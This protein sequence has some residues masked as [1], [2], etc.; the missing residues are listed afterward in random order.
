MCLAAEAENCS[1]MKFCAA[2]T[3]LCSAFSSAAELHTTS[4]C[5]EDTPSSAAAEGQQQFQVDFPRT[6]K[7]IMCMSSFMRRSVC[8]YLKPVG[9]AQYCGLSL[10]L[11][12]LLQFYNR[13]WTLL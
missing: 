7:E 12:G 3:T 6:S 11:K 5:H 13:N 10:N 8:L 4:R 1:L 9:A 2:F